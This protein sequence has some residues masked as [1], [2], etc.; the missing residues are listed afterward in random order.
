MTTHTHSLQPPSFFRLAS[1][2]PARLA[3]PVPVCA[4]RPGW[5]L[6]VTRATTGPNPT[7]LVRRA[8]PDP[9]ALPGPPAW[10]GT[11]A[12]LRHCSG[13]AQAA[14]RPSAWAT[15]S[16]PGCRVT[17]VRGGRPEPRARLARWE[18]RGR[19]GRRA[20]ERGAPS[21]WVVGLCVFCLLMLKNCFCVCVQTIIVWIDGRSIQSFKSQ[22]RRGDCGVGGLNSR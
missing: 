1:A 9:P 13:T 4:A 22:R 19:R 21:F 8:R 6:L 5:A 18:P 11:R 15:R 3:H 20:C 10:W 14:A 7:S 16:T 12:P 17:P 2:L